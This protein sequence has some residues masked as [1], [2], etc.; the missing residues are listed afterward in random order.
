MGALWR[1]RKD[2]PT[3]FYGHIDHP[4][5]TRADWD[6]YKQRFLPDSPGR[7][8]EQWHES[9]AP[10]LKASTEPVALYLY[11]FFFRLGFYSL[12]MER[13]LT[14]FHEEPDL[15]RDIFAWWGAFALQVIRPLLACGA[16]DCV[17]FT[18]DLAGKNGPLISPATYREFWHPHQDP[19][20][21]A[22]L[23]ADV[24][25]ICQWTAGQVGPL[26]PEMLAHGF[27]CTWPLE[28]CAGMD[29]PALRRR[30]GQRL[31]L[32][33]NVA[34]EAVIAGPER[35]DAEV[36]RLAPLMEAGG[37]LP[38][39]DDMASPDMPFAHYRH[40]IERLQAIRLS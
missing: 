12:G 18:E 33:G 22:V 20:L 25:V 31:L 36:E 3:L 32:G 30:Y 5:K 28:V 21:Q 27:N 11:P 38:A 19:I 39:L 16:I 24:P 10:S 35:I 9:V 8:A 17:L 4:V 13:F 26:L 7:T 6:A 23:E 1:Q 37:F 29:A 40:L 14:A 15:I 2:N 34:K